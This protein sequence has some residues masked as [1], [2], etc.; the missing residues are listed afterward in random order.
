MGYYKTQSDGTRV[1]VEED[2]KSHALIETLTAAA[3][4]TAEDSGK[5]FILG[6]AAGAAITLL[7]LRF[8]QPRAL[9]PR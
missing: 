7:V 8:A 5:S 1:W 3:T 4:L 9:L 2:G 6:A